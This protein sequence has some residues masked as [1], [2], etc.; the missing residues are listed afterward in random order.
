MTPVSAM[1]RAPTIRFQTDER[2]S[3]LVLFA[4]ILVATAVIY[5]LLQFLVKL[6]VEKML[7][8]HLATWGRP[9]MAVVSL[10]LGVL[11]FLGKK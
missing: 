1:N 11:C 6:I 9:A 4:D 8:K 3:P 5:F 7:K 2:K 10:I